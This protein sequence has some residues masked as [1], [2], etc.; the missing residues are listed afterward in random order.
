MSDTRFPETWAP[1]MTWAKH[2]AK[3]KYDLTGSNLLPCS[4]DELPGARDALEIYGRN[5]DGWP[6]LVEAIAS[7]FG[8]ATE[9]VA[10]AP[11]ASGA[12]YLALAALVRPGDTVLV[13]W[14][15]YDPHMGAARFLGAN[16]TTFQ[17]G[18][19]QGFALDADEVAASITS[20]TRAIVLTN[21]HNPSGA[22]AEPEALV[23]VGKLA[24]VVGAKVIVDEVYLD[25]LEGVDNSPAATRDDVFISTNSLTKSYGL[26]GIRVGWVLA[27]PET[28][29]RINRVRDVIDAV[30]S[31]PSETLGVLA[32][33]QLDGLLER[34][35]GVLH[36]GQAIMREFMAAHP[37]L[38]WVQPIGGSVAFPRIQGVEDVGPFVTRAAADFDVGVTPGSYFG[39]PAHFRV[40]VAG[41]RD[42]LEDGLA[43]LG[44]ALTTHFGDV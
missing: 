31:I 20:E 13:E 39:A 1:Y 14:P 41:E 23:E 32:F 10:T 9:R 25:A 15:G 5:D 42:V 37:R 26:A 2:H 16:V 4:M 19:E 3:A 38:E 30:G 44:R 12:N 7:R 40:A 21:L 22:Y 43:A 17:R 27:D 18:W 33:E 35:R 28:V 24:K 36:P 6:P 11:G 29:E 8:V 34:A